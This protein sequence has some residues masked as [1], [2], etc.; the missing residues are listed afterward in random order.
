MDDGVTVRRGPIEVC[1]VC[2]PEA[3]RWLVGRSKRRALEAWLDGWLGPYRGGAPVTAALVETN[4]SASKG[5]DGLEDPKHVLRR[6][7][8]CHGVVTQF[9]TAASAP[10]ATARRPPSRAKGLEDHAATSAVGDLMRSAGF[11]LRPFP[12]TELNTG[13]LDVGVYGARVTKRRRGR[14]DAAYLANLVAA[15]IGEANATGFVRKKG[16]RPLHEA[17]ASFLCAEHDMTEHEARKLV[18]TAVEQ[19]RLE[20]GGRG[21]VLLFDALGCRR[22]WP[23][24]QVQGDGRPDAWMVRDGTAVVRIRALADEVLRPAGSGDWSDRWSPA[25]HTDFR[26]MDV[27][28]ADGKAPTFVV[29]GSASMARCMSACDSSRLAARGKA[30]REDWHALGTTEILVLDPGR[31]RPDAVGDQ[32]AMLCRVA[33][34]SDRVLRWPSPLHLARAIVRD[35]PFHYLRDADLEVE[36][37]EDSKRMRF[38]LGLGG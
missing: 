21:M 28:A 7:L 3:D 13:T 1:L 24:L 2:P 9:I 12:A 31:W 15:S 10:D 27:V 30:L 8:A 18:E 6:L 38:D 11:F 35:H 16:W 14:G 29:S 34:T 32:V 26:P 23:C 20:A 36:E 22:F 19:L 5:D 25:R 37:S 4:E 17:T 33:P